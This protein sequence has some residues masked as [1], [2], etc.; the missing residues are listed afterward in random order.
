M[1]WA[2]RSQ[3]GCTPKRNLA[4]NML[5]LD[6]AAR[7]CSN[8]PIAARDLLALV[9]LDS[10]AAFPSPAPSFMMVVFK[11]T[12]APFA[13]IAMLEQLYHI[14]HAVAMVNGCPTFAWQASAGI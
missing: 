10:G 12:Q 5:G 4:V 9:A 1:D 11:Q 14:L 8:S 6:V 13:C 3:W 7:I 2:S